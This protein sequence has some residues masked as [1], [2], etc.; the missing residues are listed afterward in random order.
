MV[1]HGRRKPHGLQ[2]GIGARNEIG[3]ARFAVG[4]RDSDG[5]IEIGSYEPQVVYVH[6]RWLREK[7]E[8]DLANPERILTIRGV[9]YKLESKEVR[10]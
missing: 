5:E 10:G 4:K 1:G 6:I 3:S 7:I 2:L 8:E 9:G